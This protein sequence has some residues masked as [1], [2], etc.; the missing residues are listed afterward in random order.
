MRPLA[1]ERGDD[2]EDP[3][4]VVTHLPRQPAREWRLEGTGDVLGTIKN[5]LAWAT[6][7]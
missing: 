1:G 5:R 7:A 6:A 4:G 2:V 3:L